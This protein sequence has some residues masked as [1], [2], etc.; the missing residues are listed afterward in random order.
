MVVPTNAGALFCYG[1]AP[2]VT[3]RVTVALGLE[4]CTAKSVQVIDNSNGVLAS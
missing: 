1:T 4:A 2:V 3:V